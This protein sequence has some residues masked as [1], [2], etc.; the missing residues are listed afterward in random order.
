MKTILITGAS[1][2]LGLFLAES[3]L[4][5]DRDTKVIA[6]TRKTNDALIKLKKTGGLQIIEADYSN[7]DSLSQAVAEIKSKNKMID[8]VIHNASR[9]EKD[10]HHSDDLWRVC[11]RWWMHRHNLRVE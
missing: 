3:V 11:V 5:N 10:K 6:L 8:L 4:L 7:I 9:F 1:R 2:R